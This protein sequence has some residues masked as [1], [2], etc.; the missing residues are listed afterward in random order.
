MTAS[1][2]TP[3]S[4]EININQVP[5][6]SIVEYAKTV[7]DQVNMYVGSAP[8][9][10]GK[11]DIVDVRLMPPSLCYNTNVTY[12]TQENGDI[13]VHVSNESGARTPRNQI[14]DIRWYLTKDF[15]DEGVKN[16]WFATRVSVPGDVKY[17]YFYGGNFPEEAVDRLIAIQEKMFFIKTNDDGTTEQTRPFFP[18][19]QEMRKIL[20]LKLFTDQ[21]TIPYIEFLEKQLGELNEA[22]KKL[23]IN[24]SMIAM[25]GPNPDEIYNRYISR[26]SQPSDRTNKMAEN[27]KNNSMSGYNAAVEAAKEF[28]GHLLFN[29][30]THGIWK[31]TSQTINAVTKAE[32]ENL[33][34]AKKILGP[35]LQEYKTAN[36]NHSQLSGD[37]VAKKTKTGLNNAEKAKNMQDNIT[38]NRAQRYLNEIEVSIAEAI[39]IYNDR[40]KQ[41][42][43]KII[44]LNLGKIALFAT[45]G[46]KANLKAAELRAYLN[47]VY[48]DER[49]SKVETKM[50]KESEKTG[51]RK[52]KLEIKLENDQ[53]KLSDWLSEFTKAFIQGKTSIR[54]EQKFRKLFG[55]NLTEITNEIQNT[56]LKNTEKSYIYLGHSTG[57]QAKDLQR[58]LMRKL[59]ISTI[60]EMREFYREMALRF[61]MEN[62]VKNSE[63]KKV[64]RIGHLQTL[65]P[66]TIVD[67]TSFQAPTIETKPSPAS[68]N[69]SQTT[70]L[71]TREV[72]NRNHSVNNIQKLGGYMDLF[73]GAIQMETENDKEQENG[74]FKHDKKAVKSELVINKPIYKE[75]L[76]NIATTL[77]GIIGWFCK[78]SEI[79]IRAELKG[80]E[81][82]RIV[83]TIENF[84]PVEKQK[85]QYT[86]YYVMGLINEQKIKEDQERKNELKNR[87]TELQ[88]PI[89]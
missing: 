45:E 29:V 67:V 17:D 81:A 59:K 72:E 51:E 70:T 76:L 57:N 86:I 20:T 37:Y 75:F 22:C 82:N 11:S 30:S 50:I 2:S 88:T 65:K 42:T 89:A 38:I 3:L 14:D 74:N 28:G 43:D 48:G 21:E 85:L 54:I 9:V 25:V 19:S 10:T 33:N 13:F 60:V 53:E 63:G 44:Q 64:G 61:E 15:V 36:S 27:A 39:K 6:N 47:D 49:V 41:I 83:E 26:D 46:D 78:K 55:V 12:E 66:A 77:P 18:N 1:T 8:Q 31:N 52:Q 16:G 5:T 35:L 24:M 84:S 34:R 56:I 68:I 79:N 40:K 7:R 62:N 69:Q 87:A 23:N 4:P 73:K 32:T 58:L 80:L 71:L